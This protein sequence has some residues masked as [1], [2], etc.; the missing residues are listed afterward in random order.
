MLQADW[1]AAGGSGNVNTA[2]LSDIT[3]GDFEATVTSKNA[4]DVGQTVV[5]VG[6]AGN[7]LAL[8]TAYATNYQI[9]YD[10][11]K[12]VVIRQKVL[13]LKSGDF[14][15]ITKVYDGDTKIAAAKVSLKT[16][17]NQKG[18]VGVVGDEKVT[19]AHTRRSVGFRR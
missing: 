19:V 7:A 4:S 8:K 2:T 13:T 10:T 5:F 1:T 6:T 17:G 15:A 14:N 9:E 18:L 3:T 16:A 12:K 11:S